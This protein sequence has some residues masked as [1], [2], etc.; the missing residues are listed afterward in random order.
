MGSALLN[1]AAQ[2]SAELAGISP[3]PDSPEELRRQVAARL[4]AHRERRLG[5]D[6]A[7]NTVEQATGSAPRYKSRIASSVAERYSK[8]QSYR[9]FLA[10]EAERAVQQARAAAEVAARNAQAIAQ[11]QQRLL[12][13]LAQQAAAA[14]L[15]N[16][17]FPAND[18]A[19]LVGEAASDASWP[20]LK[21]A[22]EASTIAVDANSTMS[23]G[24]APIRN[25]ASAPGPNVLAHTE[26]HVAPALRVVL[27]DA[28]PA[29]ALN[30]SAAPNP[31]QTPPHSRDDGRNEAEALALD[32]EIS[33]RQAPVFEEPAGPPMALPA[34]LIEF[35]RQLVASRKAR[36]RYAEGPLRDETPAPE[37]RGQLRIFEVDPGQISSAPERAERPA[38]PEPS[39][40]SLWLDAPGPRTAHAEPV[41]ATEDAPAPASQVFAQ[42]RV[43]TAK[44]SRRML[45]GGIDLAITAVAGIGCAA[46]FA[47]TTGL[48]AAEVPWRM[49][50]IRA[51]AVDVIQTVPLSTLSLSGLAA[52]LLLSITLQAIFFTF[53][54]ATPGMRFAR[55][56]LC[57]FADDNPSRAAMRL[58]VPALLLSTCLFGLGFW[59]ALLDQD[60]LTLHDLISRTY[61]RSY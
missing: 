4:A 58:R 34:N 18:A 40:T 31:P 6:P 43:Y 25:P 24:N 3:I 28:S 50:T 10:A 48:L 5:K 60:R 35:P 53:S 51:V 55:I 8:A 17:D 49:E 47:G 37:L 45:A 2:A 56:A 57:T 14:S 54:D 39:W 42:P 7:P 38:V 11:A 52:L 41:S 12:N 16:T 30:P 44:L 23:D 20:D 29:T 27:Y 19:L 13:D 36:P 26:T 1:P 9:A 61:Q 59:W 22:V 15:R 21:S 33:F 46:A 32:E